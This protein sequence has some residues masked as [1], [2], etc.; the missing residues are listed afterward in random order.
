MTNSEKVQ[1]HYFVDMSHDHLVCHKKEKVWKILKNP[2]I[3]FTELRCC[4][5]C[6]VHMPVTE[7]TANNILVWVRSHEFP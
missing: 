6:V 5:C 4:K 7:F 2:L 3:T 1:D